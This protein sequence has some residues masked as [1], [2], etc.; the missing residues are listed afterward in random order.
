MKIH[1]PLETP[2]LHLTP[3]TATDGD[4]LYLLERDPEVKRYGGGT[5]TRLQTEELLQ[6]FITQVAETG[7]G[8]IAIKQKTN[9]ELI[10]LCGLYLDDSDNTRAELFFGLARHRWGQGFAT[11]A[12]HALVDAAFRQS[13]LRRIVAQVHQENV[14]SARVLERLGMR[15]VNRETPPPE[16]TYELM[17]SAR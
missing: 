5:L 6:T 13:G 14:R 12:C 7:L 4:A 2:R 16:L 1:Y 8:A 11:E 10:G 15:C 9:A 3:F 17:A